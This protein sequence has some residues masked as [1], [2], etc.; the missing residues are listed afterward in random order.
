MSS[1]AISNKQAI[2]AILAV[3]GAIVGFL[4]WLIYFAPTVEGAA[5]VA[6]LPAVNACLNA[7]SA[8]LVSLGVL[9]IKNG[10]RD[11]HMRF[12]ISATIASGLFLVCYIIYHTFQGDTK[13]Q[14]QGFIRPIY[15]FILISH[16]ILSVAVVP[17]I[18]STLFFAIFKRFDM[19]RRI[20]RFTYPVWLYVSV[21]GVLVFLLLRFYPA[22]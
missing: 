14:G 17:M 1:V 21:T 4:F 6:F 2:G 19:H 11:A 22:G 15:F 18:L 10:K 3:S 5:N 16:I 12:M 9:A 20:A 8:V 13:F 7:T